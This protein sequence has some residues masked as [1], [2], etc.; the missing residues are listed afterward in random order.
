[1]KPNIHITFE[2]GRQA[3]LEGYP[4]HTLWWDEKRKRISLLYFTM[5]RA[6]INNV[7]KFEFVNP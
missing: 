6:T 2:D 3:V 5:A 4:I 7:E 1:M